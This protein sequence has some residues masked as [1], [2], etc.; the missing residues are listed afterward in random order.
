MHV[1]HYVALCQPQRHMTLL[2]YNLFYN[3]MRANMSRCCM[4]AMLDM[5]QR[6]CTTMPVACIGE[7]LTRPMHCQKFTNCQMSLH[8]DVTYHIIPRSAP[9]E[10]LSC[11]KKAF[12]GVSDRSYTDD[13]FD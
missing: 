13:K 8:A 12:T 6:T 11:Q 3:T 4:H 7:C 10:R 1:R 5:P 2:M 9:V